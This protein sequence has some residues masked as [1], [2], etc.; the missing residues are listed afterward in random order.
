MEPRKIEQQPSERPRPRRW[1]P[2]GAII[3]AFIIVM[4]YTKAPFVEP[5]RC[6]PGSGTNAADVVMLS[7]SWCGFCRQARR[8][9]VEKNIDYCEYDIEQT[10]DG[11]KLYERSQYGAI[12]VLFVG[13]ATLVGFNR[14]AIEQALSVNELLRF[15]DD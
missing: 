7:A 10:S 15:D 1:L 3:V 8:F 13:D 11:A 6:R 9:L 2:L 5:V 4:Q 14:G 12:P